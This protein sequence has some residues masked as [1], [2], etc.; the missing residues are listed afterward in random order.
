[1][2]SD[3]AYKIE[4]NLPVMVG[5]WGV[6]EDVPVLDKLLLDP[7]E[8]E[9]CITVVVGKP[10]PAE[11]QPDFTAYPLF[12]ALIFFCYIEDPDSIKIGSATLEESEIQPE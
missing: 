6:H 10:G 12:S 7:A 3:G 4:R 5:S 9:L 11:I 1:M 2:K 8:S